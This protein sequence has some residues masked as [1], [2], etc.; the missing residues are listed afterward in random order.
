M[1]L[2]ALGFSRRAAVQGWVVH[3]MQ[4]PVGVTS[5]VVGA[6]VVRLQLVGQVW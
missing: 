3:L 6:C 1:L 2:K 4:Q 5:V